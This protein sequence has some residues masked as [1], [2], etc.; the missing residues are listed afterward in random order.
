[1]RASWGRRRAKQTSYP[2]RSVEVREVKISRR[3]ERGRAP[4]S[5]PLS[6]GGPFLRSNV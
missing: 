3:I 2:S 5:M 1:M 4:W 6:L